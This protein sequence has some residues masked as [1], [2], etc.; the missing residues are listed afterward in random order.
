LLPLEQRKLA[1]SKDQTLERVERLF[2]ETPFIK[3]GSFQAASFDVVATK[4]EYKDKRALILALAV[5]FGGMVGVVYV[6]IASAMR[7]RRAAET[8]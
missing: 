5:V 8:E 6:L 2:A 3:S 1:L 7:G 4:F